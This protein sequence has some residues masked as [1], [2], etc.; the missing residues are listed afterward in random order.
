MKYLNIQ[1][2]K[3]VRASRFLSTDRPPAAPLWPQSLAYNYLCMWV[4]RPSAHFSCAEQFD[5]L[6]KPLQSTAPHSLLLVQSVF[7]FLVLQRGGFQ[8][9]EYI[10]T[11]S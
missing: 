4:K 8:V 9:R 6:I 7:P 10:E 5:E 2:F 11:L 3:V 1:G